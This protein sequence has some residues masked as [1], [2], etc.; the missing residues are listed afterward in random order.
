MDQGPRREASKASWHVYLIRTRQ[1]SLYAGITTDVA[2]RVAEHGKGKGA[3]CLRA[4]GPLMVVYQVEIESRELALKAE[5][6]I[7]KLPKSNKEGIV[8]SN[9]HL[10]DLLKRLR[11]ED[12]LA[13]TT[14]AEA[15]KRGR[16]KPSQPAL[17]KACSVRMSKG[18]RKGEEG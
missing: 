11:L 17:R 12:A 13:S 3:K 6:R 16:G 9:P 4:K 10:G 7:K 1:G 8:T 18:R 2:R 15:I 14:E 5:H